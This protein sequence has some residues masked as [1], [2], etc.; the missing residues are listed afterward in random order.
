MPARDPLSVRY[1]LVVRQALVRAIRA[2]RNRHAV[3]VWIASPRGQFKR[4]D[5]GGRTAHERAF[6]RSAYY[7][8][9]KIPY[10]MGLTPDYSLK[11][12]WGT[13]LEPSS[14]GRLARACSVRIYPRSQA[15]KPLAGRSWRDD[16][17]YRSVPGARIDDNRRAS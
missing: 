17:A 3:T 13:V 6:T 11:L 15:R 16:D 14:K 4:L 5:K 12:T 9:F 10:N 2:S 7:Q 8:V 1:D